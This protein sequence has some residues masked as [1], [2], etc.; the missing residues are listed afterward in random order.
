MPDDRATRRRADD[1]DAIHL[2]GTG[3][4]HH[5]HRRRYGRSCDPTTE[6]RA[7]VLGLRRALIDIDLSEPPS[8]PAPPVAELRRSVAL[9]NAAD[10][11]LA[12]ERCRDAAEVAG[13]PAPIR[14]RSRPVSGRSSTTP[15][16]PGR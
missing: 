1:A 3:M 6:P 4:N 2:T 16:P 5:P 12:A 10:A 9:A 7:D 13:D 8:R 15:T 11:W 14:R